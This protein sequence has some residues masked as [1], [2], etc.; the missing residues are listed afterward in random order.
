MG[1]ILNL[2]SKITPMFLAKCEGSITDVKGSLEAGRL[3]DPMTKSSVLSPLSL[4]LRCNILYILFFR[5]HH[6]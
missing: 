6:E 4:N 2:L 5:P 1:A 3:H